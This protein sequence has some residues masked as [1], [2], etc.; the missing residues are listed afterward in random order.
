MT[1]DRES[2]Q[3]AYSDIQDISGEGFANAFAN[4]MARKLGMEGPPL[5]TD[6]RVCSKFERFFDNIIQIS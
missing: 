4:A 1:I 6:D 3:K 2:A 5:P